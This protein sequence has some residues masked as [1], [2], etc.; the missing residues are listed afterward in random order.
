[1]RLLPCLALLA[2]AACSSTPGAT[3]AEAPA[4]AAETRDAPP[5]EA[6]RT[7]PFEAAVAHPSR[8]A[9]DRERDESR[10]PAR[11]L[12]LLELKPGD[13]V[14]DLMGGRGYYTELLAHLVGPKGTVYA[15]N[16]AYVIERFAGEALSER[17]AR[18]ELSQVTRVDA[19]LDA[20]PFE[21]GSLDAAFMGLFYH[22]TVWMEIDRPAM[23]QAVFEA[24]E[25]GGVWVVT[26]HHAAEGHGVDDVKSLHRIERDVVVEEVT[27][28]GFELL[29]DH[30]ALRNPGDDRTKN[31][32]DDELR[33]KT[34]RFLLV[35]RKPR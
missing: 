9:A 30:E 35:F 12:P 10:K 11:V 14:A 19:E 13:T 22:D 7:D 28:A 17:L 6:A 18:P 26:D 20:L 5:T 16:N 3:P 32:F 8:P 2:I 31:V 33:G 23:N 4:P 27:A 24:L 29:S 34:D 1:M 21:A 15:Q 25:P